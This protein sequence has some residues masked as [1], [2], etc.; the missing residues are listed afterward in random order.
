M[1][2]CTPPPPTHTLMLTNNWK[3]HSKTLNKNSCSSIPSQKGFDH[4]FFF[5]LLPRFD[6]LNNKTYCSCNHYVRHV[7]VMVVNI[8]K[9]HQKA[10]IFLG[11]S[12][13]GMSQYSKSQ[14]TVEVQCSN[15][16]PDSLFMTAL[17]SSR[18]CI[19]VSLALLPNIVSTCRGFVSSPC[20]IVYLT[21][22]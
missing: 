11:F 17:F 14:C 9:R 1:F 13:D 6:T 3:S 16:P 12:W 22:M 10:Y 2:K 20:C 15:R 7:F 8:Q 5:F 4:L 19:Q 18:G 21:R